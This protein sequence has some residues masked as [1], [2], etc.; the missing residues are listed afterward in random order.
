MDAVREF[1]KVK[2]GKIKIHIPADFEHKLVEVIVL[3]LTEEAKR[4]YKL[5]ENPDKKPSDKNDSNI[6][7]W[8]D[9][10]EDSDDF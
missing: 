6:L 5:F 1:T 9:E 3:P 4:R 2:N 8:L 7:D 10:M